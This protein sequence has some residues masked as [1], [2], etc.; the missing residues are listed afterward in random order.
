MARSS[1]IVIGYHGCERE[2]GDRIVRGDA[3]FVPSKTRYDWL[4]T[5]IYFW[6]SDEQ[7][8]REWAEEKKSRGQIREPC[9]IGAVIDLG[10]CLDLTLRENLDLLAATH[11]LY[12]ADHVLTGLPL[13]TNRDSPKGTSQNKV[14]RALDCAVINFLH[15]FMEVVNDRP[16]DTVRGVFVEG[17]RVCPGAEIYR[18]THVQLAVLNERCILGVFHPR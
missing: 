16:F 12:V 8:A 9:V 13:P 11:G 14:M 1:S 4:G 10:K 2:V 18:L 17:A 5:G 7:R 3:W 15:S 6:E